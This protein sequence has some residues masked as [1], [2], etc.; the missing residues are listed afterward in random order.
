MNNEIK[1]KLFHKLLIV[2]FPIPA[3]YLVF[4]N[5]KSWVI[6]TCSILW[7]LFTSVMLLGSIMTNDLYGYSKFI[8]LSIVIFVIINGIC[9]FFKW[10]E[11][12]HKKDMEHYSQLL[13]NEAAWE[14]YCVNENVHPRLQLTWMKL[15]GIT[16]PIIEPSSFKKT[17]NKY[18]DTSPS[19]SVSTFSIKNE[20]TKETLTVRRVKAFYKLALIILEDDKVDIDEAKKLRSWL[21]RYPESKDDYRTK[22]LY[23]LVTD[24]LEDKALDKNESLELFSLLSDYCDYFEQQELKKEPVKKEIVKDKKI[25]PKLNSKKI[26]DL[27]YAFLGELN[28]G[29]EY[30]MEYADSTGQ[31]S[32]RNIIFHS[33]ERNKQ[34]NIYITSHCLLRN[35]AR[36]FRA[37][38]I[39]SLCDVKT[40]EV[41]L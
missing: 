12:T 33:I 14:Q 30:F 15:T 6:K 35:R 36:T 25:K 3:I 31:S 32:E 29:Q 9:S 13:S 19:I 2:A 38:R 28:K 11:V 24:A 18:T 41:L 22:K 23:Q 16:R 40:G 20:V 10:A 1:M 21:Y 7:A 39:Q 8:F 37:D 27:S 34:D 5:K 17:V 4:K 26:H